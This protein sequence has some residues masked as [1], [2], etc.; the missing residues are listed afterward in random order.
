MEQI[1]PEKRRIRKLFERLM[2]RYENDTPVGLSRDEVLRMTAKM[3]R[4]NFSPKH[5]GTMAVREFLEA[6]FVD[7]AHEDLKR[8]GLNSETVT[9]WAQQQPDIVVH[10]LEGN[11]YN[12][13]VIYNLAKNADRAKVKKY[14]KPKRKKTTTGARSCHEQRA[15]QRAQK[16]SRRKRKLDE[17][18]RLTDYPR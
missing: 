14:E 5:T 3:K 7:C 15:A 4:E 8:M 9:L 17:Q 2:E 18:A 11:A 1:E 13:S 6:G 12:H 10:E 16:A